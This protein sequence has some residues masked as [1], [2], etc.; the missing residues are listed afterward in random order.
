MF[1]WDVKPLQYYYL[2]YQALYVCV[3]WHYITTD[4][5]GLPEME[6]NSYFIIF[7]LETLTFR[8]FGL[9]TIFPLKILS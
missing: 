9:C 2:P 3:C 7:L 6:V 8:I 5:S 4:Y 1:E